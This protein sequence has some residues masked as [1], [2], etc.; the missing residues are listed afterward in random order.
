[1][2]DLELLAEAAIERAELLEE[3]GAV[4]A[5]SDSDSEVKNGIP[6]NDRIDGRGGPKVILTV[7]NLSLRELLSLGQYF[8]LFV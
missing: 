3:D 1:M 2:R 7:T 8:N 4:Y 6:Y 5:E